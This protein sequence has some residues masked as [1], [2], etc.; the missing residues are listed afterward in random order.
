MPLPSPLSCLCNVYKFPLFVNMGMRSDVRVGVGFVSLQRYV[1]MLTSHFVC[2]S[3][4]EKNEGIMLGVP[5]VF[6]QI[7]LR[8]NVDIGYPV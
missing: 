5:E 7:T 6:L 1:D 2:S 3:A 4:V 8:L